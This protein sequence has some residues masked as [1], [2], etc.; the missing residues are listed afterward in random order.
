MSAA[1]ESFAGI[2]VP[3]GEPGALNDAAGEFGSIA[4]TLAGTA[5]ELRGMPGTMASWSG[6][7]SVNYAG[8]CL[9]NSTACDAA[10]VALG[11]AEHAARVY[12]F[13]LKAAQERARRAIDDARDAQGRIDQAEREIAAAQQRRSAAATAAAYAAKQ[14]SISLAAG[15]PD[16]GAEA[17]RSQAESDAAAAADDEARARR[18][19][20]HARDD[21]E[22]AQRRGHEAMDDARDAAQAAA[23][24][25]GAA[26]GSSPA[27][28]MAGGP[29][30]ASGGPP[31]WWNTKNEGWQW[32]NEDQFLSQL[33]P[34]HP[35]HDAVGPYKWWGDQIFNVG[36]DWASGAAV[37]YGAR[38]RDRA[39][40]DVTTYSLR[41]MRQFVS[42][43]GGTVLTESVVLSR[44]TTT[45][46]DAGLLA[47]AGQWST[48][49]KAI[50]WVGG[51]VAVGSAGWDQW[52]EDANNPNLTTTDRVG[53]AAGVGMYVGGS[54]V[55]G[56]AIGTML[57]PGVGTVA[58]LAIGAT[59][60][61]VAGAVA[62]S[63]EPLKNAAAAAGQWTANA[64]VDAWTW[65]GDRIGDIRGGID[66]GKQWLD[67]NINMPSVSL[68]D[69]DL[70][71]IDL[72]D[73]DMPDLN[74]F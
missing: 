8:S 28:A 71:D 57:F 39:I 53:R 35:K 54:A 34:F 22:R 66:A 2:T 59:A 61:L 45:V 58:G 46:I 68:P 49:G 74:P 50:P 11:Q 42:G 69:I 44:G 63:I 52:R 32:W 9:T 67:D 18:E 55:A 24:A 65:S 40:Q 20:E 30:A 47:K 37:A 5:G 27:Y 25:F 73:V 21:L 31:G 51:A 6:P 17:M 60:G 23:A 14:V 13:K 72:P 33:I 48:A 43:A 7:A 62:S 4:G 3:E 16:P 1:T 38:L 29:A 64:A 41:Y 19:L 26:A 70:P 10:V 36:A 56:A 12:S 15:M